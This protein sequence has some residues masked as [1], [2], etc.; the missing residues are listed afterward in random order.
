[1]PKT[2]ERFKLIIEAMPRY[3]VDAIQR[4]RWCLK[5]LKRHGLRCISCTIIAPKDCSKETDVPR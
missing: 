3:P 1:M 5:F 2:A 4:L